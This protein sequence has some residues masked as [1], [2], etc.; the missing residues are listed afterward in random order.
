MSQTS[1]QFPAS[2]AEFLKLVEGTEYAEILR[3]EAKLEKIMIDA[4]KASDDPVTREIG[5]G[6][7]DGTLTWRTIARTSAYSGFLEHGLTALW[8]F[9]FNGLAEDLAAT[10]AQAAQ[11]DAGTPGRRHDDGEDLWQG[12]RGRRRR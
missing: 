12:L 6:L 7:V 2:R 8:E 3:D 5:E 9:D 4:L 11:P 10:K 1:G